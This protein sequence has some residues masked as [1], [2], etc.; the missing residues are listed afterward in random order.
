MRVAN[1]VKQ[2]VIGGGAA[3]SFSPGQAG[4]GGRRRA[5]V[6]AVCPQVHAG[7]HQ[8]QPMLLIVLRNQDAATGFFYAPYPSMGIAGMRCQIVPERVRLT[9]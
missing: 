2:G 5:V 8:A 6:R 4:C 1:K 3:E 9:R 7:A